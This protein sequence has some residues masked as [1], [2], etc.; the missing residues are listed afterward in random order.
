M[1]SIT[2][3]RTIFPDNN[4]GYRERTI[5]NEEGARV[6]R[7]TTLGMYKVMGKDSYFEY[8]F[9]CRGYKDFTVVG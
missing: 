4:L 6:L 3:L 2:Q 8:T 1:F 7:T 5:L 9:N